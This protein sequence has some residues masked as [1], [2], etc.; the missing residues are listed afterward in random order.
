MNLPIQITFRNL[1]HSD[2]V[3]ARIREEA[4]KL[5]S[6]YDGMMSCRVMVEVPHH[7]RQR[8]NPFH[9][10]ID[11]GVPGAELV[12]KHEPTLHSSM[13]KVEEDCATKEMEV[14]GAHKDIY[15]AIRDAFKAARR[16][17][18]DYARRQ[19]AQ[20]KTHEPAK[21]ARVHRLFPD[22]GYGFLETPDGREI[23]FHKNSVLN[24]GFDQIEVGAEVRFVEE[25]GI[26]G[27]QASTV[28]LG[29]KRKGG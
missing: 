22:E 11:V 9:I 29:R 5:E 16:E 28:R 7:H 13:Q 17:L 19:R 12:V 18:Q 1:N 21:I 4:A 20:V 3:E 8:G 26:K 23:Y 6:F 25:Q 14:Q 10:R 15:V 24:G 2:A 27:T